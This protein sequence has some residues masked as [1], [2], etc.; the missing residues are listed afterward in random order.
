MSESR[1]SIEAQFTRVGPYPPPHSPS[2]P[3]FRYEC[4]D[5]DW[6]L[7]TIAATDL[8]EDNRGLLDSHIDFHLAP[9][10]DAWPPAPPADPEPK[11][12]T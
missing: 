8:T 6:S 4:A 5:C 2:T 10:D 11:E 1:P 9:Y 7:V 3:A 12:A